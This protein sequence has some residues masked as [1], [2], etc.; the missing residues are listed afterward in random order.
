[1]TDPAKSR[2]RL[3]G[4]L[5]RCR[6]RWPDTHATIDAPRVL[7][8]GVAGLLLALAG[9]HLGNS[10]I[11]LLHLELLL[12]APFLRRRLGL[13]L[14]LLSLLTETARVVQGLFGFDQLFVSIPL[15]V[16][17]LRAFP[18]SYAV[19]LALL[20]AAFLG[21]LALMLRLLPQ[22]TWR[23]GPWLAA[24]ALAMVLSAKS[25][26][27]R[28]KQNLVG[29]SFGYLAGQLTFSKMFDKG[30]TVPG[31]AVANHPAAVAAMEAIAA[32]QNLWLI[33]VE[34]MGLPTDAVLQRAL[35]EPLLGVDDLNAR[36]EIES[37]RLTSVGSTIHGELRALCGGQLAHGL[38]DDDNRDCLPSRMASAGY[39]TQAIHANAAAMYGRNIWYRKVGFQKY[40]S[41]DTEPGLTGGAGKRWGT[42]L[43]GDTIAWTNSTAF[44]PGQPR[45]TYLLTVSTHLPAERLPG[46]TEIDGCLAK[47][48]EHACLH[49]SNLRLVMTQLAQ[50]AK[51]RDD[52]V[53]VLIGDHPPPFVSPGSR[54]AFS[55]TDVPWIKLRPRQS[56]TSR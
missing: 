29:T 28:V 48:T 55:S 53:I 27:D 43:D 50:A 30:Y 18:A 14:M 25:A 16:H 51:A 54:S 7:F 24:A 12:L 38:F 10:S 1:M 15:L 44:P 49:L 9:R 36:Y 56:L 40:S 21:G 13:A 45:F 52:T 41:G 2:S 8:F 20:L 5:H 37:G 35:F 34:S 46:A 42:R 47:A 6:T 11:P 39:S 3:A 4:A 32:R 17:N 31:G 26:E 19:Q 23:V 22:R 33:V